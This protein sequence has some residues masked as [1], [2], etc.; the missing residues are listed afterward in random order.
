VRDCLGTPVSRPRRYSSRRRPA[1]LPARL[2][3]RPP[4]CLPARLPARPPTHPHALADG[5][6]VADRRFV[7]GAQDHKLGRPRG[8]Q[9]DLKGGARDGAGSVTQHEAKHGHGVLVWEGRKREG[10]LRGERGKVAGLRGA[11]ER[12]ARG[13]GS[14]K[15][16]AAATA[17]GEGSRRTAYNR[18]TAPAYMRPPN[19]FGNSAPPHPS[20]RIARHRHC[21][22]PPAAARRPWPPPPPRG[23]PRGGPRPCCGTRPRA[24]RGPPAGTPPS[25]SPERR[26]ER[27]VCHAGCIKQ[28]AFGRKA[29]ELLQGRG[30]AGASR[31]RR[32]Q[33]HCTACQPC[34]TNCMGQSWLAPDAAPAAGRPLAAARWPGIGGVVE[35]DRRSTQL[36][37]KLGIDIPQHLGTPRPATRSLALSTALSLLSWAPAVHGGPACN[38]IDG[39]ALLAQLAPDRPLPEDTSTSRG[40]ALPG[41]PCAPRR[42][43]RLHV[44][45]RP[46]SARSV[47]RAV[48]RACRRRCRRCH[49]PS[50][51]PIRPRPHCRTLSRSA[52]CGGCAFARAAARR[53]LRCPPGGACA[54]NTEKGRQAAGPI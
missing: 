51:R 25:H 7:S 40:P 18:L 50:P 52:P 9:L 3:A 20:R 6:G 42:C 29:P 8:R 19:A 2:P 53:V 23:P 21:K 54:C 46:P 15:G 12:G 48:A 17:L 34:S 13:I 11:A 14:G 44:A 26:G 24:P 1:Y 47:R 16:R 41:V 22:A 30:P 31:S 32:R 45:S 36:T 27:G 39:R 28:D 10:E 37:S 38:R 35:A 49:C 43:R 5:P 33:K 4:A